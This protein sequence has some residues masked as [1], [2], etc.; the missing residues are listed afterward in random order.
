MARYGKQRRAKRK[1]RER[2]HEQWLKEQDGEAPDPKSGQ[3]Y[4]L[5]WPDM[6]MVKNLNWYEAHKI[7]KEAT[8]R[9]MIFSMQDLVGC[10][11]PNIKES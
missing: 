3:F 6:K 2:E 8:D 5:L 10:S 11:R 1:R 7:W 9:A 4:V